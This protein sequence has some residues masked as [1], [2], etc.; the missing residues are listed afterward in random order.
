MA[1][2]DSS[3]LPSD[4][5]VPTTSPDCPSRITGSIDGSGKTEVSQSSSIGDYVL[6]RD[7]LPLY[8]DPVTNGTAT[9]V[10]D[11]AINGQLMSVLAN[12][13]YAIFQ[14]KQRHPYFSGHSQQPEFTYINLIPETDVI[15]RV[16]Y[17]SSTTSAPYD[18]NKDGFYLE[19]S[20][21]TVKMVIEK[22]GS[23][24]VIEQADWD[25]PVS[26][27][28]DWLNFNVTQLDFL[29]LGGTSVTQFQLYDGIKHRA[30]IHNHSNHF[31]NTIVGDPSQPI[32]AEIRST[33][34]TGSLIFSCANVGTMGLVTTLFGTPAV[35]PMDVALTGLNTGTEYVFLEIKKTNASVELFS[36]AV[37]IAATGASN[38]IGQWNLMINPTITGAMPLA[39]SMP[40]NYLEYS[41]GTSAQTI[42]SISDRGHVVGGGSVVNRSGSG[43]ELINNLRIG[44]DIAGVFDS[45]VLTYSPLN[46][47]NQNVSAVY[48]GSTI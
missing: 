19:S 40:D 11:S 34:G 13:D 6:S 7:N 30:S 43:R 15:K 3:S 1:N 25:L 14:T 45:L 44:I 33:G 16:G 22:E 47:S 10:Y 17:Y 2:C 41:V 12:G 38:G 27:D 31:A 39:I 18:A 46:Q 23:R 42:A 29:Y 5:S 26:Q 36:R 28:M 8:F 20:N 24:Q 4:I 9:S 21:G 48:S 37:E 35:I 32:R